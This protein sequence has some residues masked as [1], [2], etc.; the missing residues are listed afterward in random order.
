[1][2]ALRC[3]PL[4]PMLATTL[5]PIARPLTPAACSPIPLGHSS[6]FLTAAVSPAMAAASFPFLAAALPS[7]RGG[8]RRI[9]CWCWEEV[10]EEDVMA[11]EHWVEVED[12]PAR[13]MAW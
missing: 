11:V 9:F 13:G 6:H 10:V 3:D 7:P 5:P 1:M 2:D 4:P 12:D 8:R